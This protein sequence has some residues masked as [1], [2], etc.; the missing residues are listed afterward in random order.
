MIVITGASEG[1]GKALA[2][3]YVRAGMRVIG[4]SRGKCP[5]GVEHV[6]TDLTKEADIK[7]AAKLI[8]KDK[9]PIEALINCAGVLSLEKL[10]KITSKQLDH[11]MSVN[12]RAP[13]LLTSALLNKIR[14]DEGDILNVSSTVGT[15]GYVDQ[16]VYGSSKW[17]LRGFSTNLQTELKDTMC[18][19]IS[20]CPGGFQSGIFE[21]ATGK[22]NQDFTFWMRPEDIAVF[23]KQILDLPKNM[24]VTEIIL[25][26]KQVS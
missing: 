7:K 10:E 15:K 2:E 25:N 18:R 6:K 8:N 5:E 20:F 23:V 13:I 24:E 19:V 12:V 1:L 17:A 4:L 16:A 14:K 21:K 3:V 11:V 22:K 9:E 26:R